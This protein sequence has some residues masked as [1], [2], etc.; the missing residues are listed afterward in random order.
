M[1]VYVLENGCYSDTHIVGVF[2]TRANAALAARIFRD[3][4][5]ITEWEVDAQVEAMRAGHT[6]YFVRLQRDTG[7]VLE[8]DK[9]DSSYGA[10]SDVVSEDVDKNLYT[11]CW[12]ENREHAV[13][14][15]AERRR[16]YLALPEV[17]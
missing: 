5:N 7:D 8:C 11:H 14:V 10:F 3:D 1:K 16:A 13:K 6:L 9:S 15:A 2:S 12:A 4:A 17:R